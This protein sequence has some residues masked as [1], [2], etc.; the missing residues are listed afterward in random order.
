MLDLSVSYLLFSI[1]E[2]VVQLIWTF[3]A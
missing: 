2:Y 3:W 1:P